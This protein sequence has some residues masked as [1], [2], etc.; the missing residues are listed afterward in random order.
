M[1]NSLKIKEK[2]RINKKR[3]WLNLKMKPKI[4]IGD[5]IHF[6]LRYKTKY[7]KKQKDKILSEILSHKIQYKIE[8]IK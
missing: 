1:K 5:K 3:N 2:W 6:Y 8:V 4:I 7:R